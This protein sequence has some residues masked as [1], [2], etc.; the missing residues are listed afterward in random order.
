MRVLK[1][2]LSYPEDLDKRLAVDLMYDFEPMK[3]LT[4][5]KENPNIKEIHSL[6][7]KVYNFYLEKVRNWQEMI[8][9]SSD[10]VFEIVSP[11]F[12]SDNIREIVADGDRYLVFFYEDIDFDD[13]LESY[14][15]SEEMFWNMYESYFDSWEEELDGYKLHADPYII[16]NLYDEIIIKFIG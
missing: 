10:F 3:K 9:D 8:V 15:K 16:R 11:N 7:N 6:I 14:F 13:T 4:D 2:K 1:V 5:R 12:G